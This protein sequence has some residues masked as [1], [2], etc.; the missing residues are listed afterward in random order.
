ME[1]HRFDGL[2]VVLFNTFNSHIA[3]EHIAAFQAKVMARGATSFEHRA[4]LRG[5]MTRQLTPEE[6]IARVDASWFQ[7]PTTR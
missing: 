7:Q 6:L 3:D 2:H 5:R 4:V 1:H